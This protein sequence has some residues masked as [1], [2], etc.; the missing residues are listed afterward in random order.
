MYIIRYSKV[1][2]LYYIVCIISIVIRICIFLLSFQVNV[3]LSTH[4]VGGLSK[5]D[6]ELATFMEKACK[7]CV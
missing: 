4:D 5:K 6:V 2:A 1:T 3:T 7:E